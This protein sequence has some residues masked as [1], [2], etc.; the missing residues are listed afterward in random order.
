MAPRK[1]ATPPVTVD[2]DLDI[3][4]QEAN[5]TA[6]PFTFRI[7]GHV[8]TLATADDSDFRVLDALSRN[9]LTGAIRF[10]LGDE[11]YAKFT[12]KPVSMRT[13][14]KVLAGWS[15][16]KGISLGE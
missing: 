3:L 2:L 15:E 7:H 10:L 1:P 16:H 9:D 4:D 5:E 11:Q 13:L 6:V 14:K 12:E 8:L